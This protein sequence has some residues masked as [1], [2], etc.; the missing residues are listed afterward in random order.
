MFRVLLNCI[1]LYILK[2]IERVVLK[3]VHYGTCTIC[4][5]ASGNLLYD[6][7]NPKLVLCDNPEGWEEEG[8]ERAV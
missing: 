2:Y 8:D 6:V 7:E 5:K 1:T 3:H 4:K